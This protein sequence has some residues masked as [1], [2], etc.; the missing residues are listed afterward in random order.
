MVDVDDTMVKRCVEPKARVPRGGTLALGSTHH[1]TIVSSTSTIWFPK[2][3]PYMINHIVLKI[4]HTAQGQ[5]W[6]Q[7]NPFY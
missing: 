1:F 7:P 2:S 4:N 3:L 6:D 5:P